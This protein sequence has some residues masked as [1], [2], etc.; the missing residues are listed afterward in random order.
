MCKFNH[1]NLS[2]SQSVL[3]SFNSNACHFVRLTGAMRDK[4]AWP[5]RPLILSPLSFLSFFLSFSLL[6]SVPIPV[7]APLA[8]IQWLD[9]QHMRVLIVCCLLAAV[10]TA[11]CGEGK[12]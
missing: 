8:W 3:L 2:I 7:P 10:L 12:S 6:L 5:K 11:A 4:L 9:Q 1:S